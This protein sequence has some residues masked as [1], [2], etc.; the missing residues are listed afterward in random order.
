MKQRDRGS[1][2]YKA[3]DG[4]SEEFCVVGAQPWPLWVPPDMPGAPIPTLQAG[5]SDVGIKLRL[6][7]DKRLDHHTHLPS[8][9]LQENVP[10]YSSF[11]AG[12]LTPRRC[13]QPLENPNHK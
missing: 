3:G 6:S 4:V 1:E 8:A 10:P 7:K 12:L 2:K 13:T 9:G 5:L 11:H